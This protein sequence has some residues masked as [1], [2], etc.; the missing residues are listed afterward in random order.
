MD[1]MSNIT[2]SVAQ[3]IS[4]TLD[5]CLFLTHIS[6]AKLLEVTVTEILYVE[7][8]LKSKKQFGQ[9]VSVWKLT[10]SVHRRRSMRIKQVPLWNRVKSAHLAEFVIPNLVDDRN[11]FGSWRR[12]QSSS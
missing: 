1:S 6:F 10:G 12:F 5:L 3:L 7:A 2:S 11:L 4:G 8:F 9:S